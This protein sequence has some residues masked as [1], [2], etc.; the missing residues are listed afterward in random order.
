MAI[1]LLRGANGGGDLWWGGNN[2]DPLG[3]GG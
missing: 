1:Y 3:W 2:D